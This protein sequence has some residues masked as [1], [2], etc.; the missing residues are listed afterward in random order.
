[1]NIDIEIHEVRNPGW[2]GDYYRIHFDVVQPCVFCEG[3]YYPLA[4]MPRMKEKGGAK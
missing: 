3:V 2:S 1:M 4:D